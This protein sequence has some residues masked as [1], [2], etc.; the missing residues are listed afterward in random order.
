MK[1]FQRRNETSSSLLEAYQETMIEL[2]AQARNQGRY[3]ET[4]YDVYKRGH[5]IS[6]FLETY[7]EANPLEETQ[8]VGVVTHWN[9]ISGLTC[10]DI[11]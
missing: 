11:D 7:L 2:G 6:E 8:R 5:R 9:V 10:R 4:N 1:M 3:Y